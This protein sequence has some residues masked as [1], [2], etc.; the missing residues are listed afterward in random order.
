[1][2]GPDT[3]FIFLSNLCSQ[4]GSKRSSNACGL[5]PEQGDTHWM[6]HALT[7]EPGCNKPYRT[8]YSEITGRLCAV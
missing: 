8:V 2:R 1:M 5:H 6:L 3:A 7:E 4:S